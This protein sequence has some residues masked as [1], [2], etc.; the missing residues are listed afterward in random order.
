MD[1]SHNRPKSQQRGRIAL[2]LEH[3]NILEE[4]ERRIDT[5]ICALY[6]VEAEEAKEI[7]ANY[8]F[9]RLYFLL[10]KRAREHGMTEST[11]LEKMES[12][13]FDFCAYM[14]SQGQLLEMAAVDI[15][16]KGLCKSEN[17]GQNDSDDRY[18]SFYG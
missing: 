5:K 3:A 18:V 8:H 9:D 14:V 11:F 1:K 10:R 4:D 15:L 2:D 13:N 6:G 16:F 7:H 12:L 17:N